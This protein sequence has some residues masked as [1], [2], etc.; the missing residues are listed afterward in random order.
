MRAAMR[1]VAAVTVGLIAVGC[2]GGDDN[3][4]STD[5]GGAKQ[6]PSGAPE[7]V[8]VTTSGDG[9]SPPTIEVAAGGSIEFSNFDQ[10]TKHTFTTDDGSIDVVAKTNETVTI[11][12][13][14][15]EPGT[16]EFHCEIHPPM[17]GE[18]QVVE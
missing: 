11:D 17:V 6:T 2:G 15:V 1:V 10:S 7:S 3:G 18:L 16:Y 12:L 4:A 13:A 5:G 14:D 9:F 8:T